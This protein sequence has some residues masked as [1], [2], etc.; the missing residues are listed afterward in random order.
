MVMQDKSVNMNVHEEVHSKQFAMVMDFVTTD[1]L[2][3]VSVRV[4]QSTWG[5]HARYFVLVRPMVA[6]TQWDGV[7]VIQIGLVLDVII[8]LWDGVGLTPVSY[9]VSTEQLWAQSV[10]VIPCMVENN[11]LNVVGST[12]RVDCVVI[13]APVS[14][15][16]KGLVVVT[17]PLTGKVLPV[18]VQRNYVRRMNS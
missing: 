2:P 16:T 1:P 7:R 9:L 11:V 18:S 4:T 15:E 14:K 13:E 3:S 17:V 12:Y 8:V 5:K 6:V 10:F